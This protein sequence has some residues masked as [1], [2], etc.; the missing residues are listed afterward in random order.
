[1]LLFWKIRAQTKCNNALYNGGIV[2]ALVLMD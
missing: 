2:D 1:M